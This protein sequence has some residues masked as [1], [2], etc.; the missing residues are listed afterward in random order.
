VGVYFISFLAV[1]P[2]LMYKVYYILSDSLF[3]FIS[4]T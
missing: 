3:A 2:N 4:Y 1:N